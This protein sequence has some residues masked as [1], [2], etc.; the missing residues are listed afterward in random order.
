M[1]EREK[2]VC[3]NPSHPFKQKWYYY[4]P[5]DGGTL[6]G[7]LVS[8]KYC[9]S[10]ASHNNFLKTILSTLLQPNPTLYGNALISVSKNQLKK[11]IDEV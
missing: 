3:Q 9:T 1:A 11:L 10:C 5:I 6:A 8:R 7:H 2:L 4:Q